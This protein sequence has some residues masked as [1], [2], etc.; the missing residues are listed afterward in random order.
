ME[1][2]CIKVGCFFSNHTP[3]KQWARV[4]AGIHFIIIEV[5]WDVPIFT[6]WKHGPMCSIQK[7]QLPCY[8]LIISL[9]QYQQEVP[10]WGRA[11]CFSICTMMYWGYVAALR[12]LL[13]VQFAF[14]LFLSFF[15]LVR[16]LE[17]FLQC[18]CWEVCIH[19][20]LS[21][22]IRLNLGKVFR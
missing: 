2:W 14:F 8:S 13:F 16:H 18:A 4:F 20:D 21:T 19:R 9:S 1:V 6:S 10:V 15:F 11:N 12:L 5:S 17:A 3:H 7:L 22:N